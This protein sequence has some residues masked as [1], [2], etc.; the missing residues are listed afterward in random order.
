MNGSFISLVTDAHKSFLFCI[1]YYT[2]SPFL[3]SQ[4]YKNLITCVLEQAFSLSGPVLY[5]ALCFVEVW[6]LDK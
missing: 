1:I 4:L 6:G 5:N 2:K 3:Y